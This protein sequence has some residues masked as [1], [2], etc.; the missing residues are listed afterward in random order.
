MFLSSFE[1]LWKND[2]P[3]LINPVK[4]TSDRITSYNVCYTKLLRTDQKLSEV[5]DNVAVFARVNPADK[6]RIVRAFKKKGHVVAMTGDGVNDAPAIKEAD[7]GV[8]MGITGTD[9]TKQAADVV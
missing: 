9:V 6:L 2:K 5:I 7:I 1:N 3:F 4:T 8:S